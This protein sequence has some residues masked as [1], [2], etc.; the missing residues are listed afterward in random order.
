MHEEEALGKGYDAHLA[1]RL[2]GYLRPYK[3]R[4]ALAIVL[5]FVTA[6]AAAAI[7]YITKVAVDSYILP[8]F[9]GRLPAEQAWSGM[10]QVAGLFL[11]ALVAGFALQVWQVLV[12]QL[13]GQQ[14][15]YDLRMEIF[16]HLQRLPMSF[17]DRNPVG[18]LLT[19]VT[20]DVD[21][22]Y[23]LFA[24]GIVAMLTD[25]CKLLFFVGIMLWL[26]W[27]LALTVLAVL[28]LILLVTMLFRRKFRDANRRIRTAIARINAFL[29]EYISGVAV[30]QL[31]NRERKAMAQ[32][33]RVN[34]DHL[35]A[36]KDAIW[37][38]PFSIPRWSF[39]A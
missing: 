26:D 3:G 37:R 22:L 35:L 29:Q 13:V 10:Q 32:F 38:T 33:A 19:R 28:P 5:S 6:A 30:V 2:A 7:P 39:L 36:F 14:T 18:R 8:G 9:E 16:R 27:R 15:M 17:Y 34:R 31:F 4:V 12:M 23:E 20:T 11:L 24:A 1:R 21:V 25:T